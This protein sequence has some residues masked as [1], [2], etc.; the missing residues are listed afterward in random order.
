MKHSAISN[1]LQ[2]ALIRKL[3]KA[4]PTHLQTTQHKVKRPTHFKKN[5][6]E[7]DLCNRYVLR[8]RKLAYAYSANKLQRALARRNHLNVQRTNDLLPSDRVRGGVKKLA[9]A[10]RS[11]A[12][13][14]NNS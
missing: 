10:M 5:A 9:D 8:K 13:A 4:A 11:A 6:F 2:Q 7:N 12:H 1:I 14:T 3:N